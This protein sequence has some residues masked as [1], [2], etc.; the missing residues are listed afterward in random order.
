[1]SRLPVAA[2]LIVCF[3]FQTSAAED[4]V[5]SGPQAGEKLP[6]LKMKAVTGD[7]AGK[8]I[9]VV[10]QA[11]D[12]PLV[13]V[14]VHQRTRPAFGLMNT[15]TRFAASRP[16]D[17][18]ATG[19]CFLTDDATST[20]N[21]VKIV[22]QHLTKGITHG[23]SVDG[24]EGPGAYGLNRNVTLTILVAKE[25]SVTANFALIQPSIQADGPK[26]F[27]AVVDAMGGGRVPSVE[28]F[29]GQRN[30]TRKPDRMRGGQV[31]EQIR[32]LL[33]GLINKQ[34]KPEDVEK[35]AA[36]IEA[37][38]EKNPAAGKEIGRIAKTI[39]TSGKLENYGT[40]KAQEYLRAW[41]RRER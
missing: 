5:F 32:P 25:G 23:L 7:D 38:I 27:K 24:L 19:V 11:G 22:T 15:V 2:I 3:S 30:A 31:E 36:E 12:R 13:I 16:K 21:W 9:D 10:S 40:P 33:R 4:P 34:A 14:F 17:K 41:A 6:P 26:V 35:A 1:M 8:E 20:E 37:F 39:V 28:Q 18:L 29:S